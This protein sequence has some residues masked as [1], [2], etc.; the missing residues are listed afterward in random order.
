M[1]QQKLLNSLFGL[2]VVA[3]IVVLLLVSLWVKKRLSDAYSVLYAVNGALVTASA[4]T[5][6]NPFSGA[7]KAPSPLPSPSK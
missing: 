1:E 3:V 5:A 7:Y 6:V 4:A 2:V